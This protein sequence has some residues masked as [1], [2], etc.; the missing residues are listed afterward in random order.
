[1]TTKTQVLSRKVDGRVTRGAWVEVNG[2]MKF[3]TITVNY[4]KGK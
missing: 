1:M 4:G 2:Q 3:V